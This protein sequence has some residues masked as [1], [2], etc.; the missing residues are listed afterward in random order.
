MTTTPTSVQ[1]PAGGSI[2]N[3]FP[4]LSA[5]VAYSA[6]GATETVKI[7]WNVASNSGFSTALQSIVT[8]NF[9]TSGQIARGSV[10]T[11][12]AP[13]TWYLRARATDQP[14]TVSG[15]STT[16]TF[17][18][19]HKAF[20]SQHKPASGDRVAYG[21]GVIRF[22]W[23][24]GDQD[25]TDTQSAFQ[26][27]AYR[28]TNDASLF[29]TGKI[30]STAQFRDQ[31]IAVGDQNGYYYWQVKVWDA[32]DAASDWSTPIMFQ[33]SREPTVAITSPTSGGVVTV[34]NPAITWQFLS[35][36]ASP[37][38]YASVDTAYASYTALDTAQTSY[39]GLLGVAPDQANQAAWRV[40]ITNGTLAVY[41][42]GWTNGTASTHTPGSNILQQN[43]V[44]TVTVWVRD[45]G[46]YEG[47]S[48]PVNFTA[49]WVGPAEPI[50]DIVDVTATDTAGGVQISWN[51]ANY[52]SQFYEWRV[53]RRSVDLATGNPTSNWDLVGV[54]Q[55]QTGRGYVMD[56]LFEPGA[57]YQYA[58][59]QAARRYYNDIV[60]SAY[61][62]ILA[63]PES[64]YYW[65][66]S[67]ETPALNFRLSN[68]VTDN[69]GEEF[70]QA[71]YRVINRGRRVEYG[72]RYGYS[73][74]L[75]AQFRDD[76]ILGIDAKEQVARLTAIKNARARMVIRIP[77]GYLLPV[78]VGQM[79][80][81]R[82]RGVGMRE[83][84]D[85]TIPY[86]E[87]AA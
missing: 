45:S 77:F 23:L 14:G 13:G 51:A 76:P 46:A 83:F 11:R 59:V 16:T 61:T 52:D 6:G 33:L 32:G 71:E 69:F 70:E 36:N 8:P 60:E 44:Y 87:V 57:L 38:S 20:T 56:Y 2:L 63:T 53:Y 79:S 35:G 72:T 82:V 54:S 50:E 1:P 18:I 80:F 81:D 84:V 73:G 49:A 74:T 58:V 62:G 17:T 5:Y 30:V 48:P 21:T 65:V 64:I 41:D 15:W 55:Q 31:T 47:S 40:I 3:G 85:V 12:L 19:A 24:F 9:L 39:A 34:P 28:A 4:D 43:I 10:V 66:I 75:Q 68:V 27:R 26:V 67:P 29:D 22:S 78:A 86:A 7:E 37:A 25:P 42:S